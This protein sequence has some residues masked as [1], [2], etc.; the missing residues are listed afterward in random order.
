MGDQVILG[1][2]FA[3]GFYFILVIIF[4][5]LNAVINRKETDLTLSMIAASVAWAI[6]FVI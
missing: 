4:Q 5:G 1:A 2:A 6:V 3:V